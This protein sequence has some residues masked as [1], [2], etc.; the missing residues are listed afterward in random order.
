M[1]DPPAPPRGRATRSSVPRYTH[2]IWE[3]RI[4]GDMNQQNVHIVGRWSTPSEA[5]AASNFHHPMME[6]F[7]VPD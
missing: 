4:E 7:D 6:I 1:R 5:A 2:Q 3:G